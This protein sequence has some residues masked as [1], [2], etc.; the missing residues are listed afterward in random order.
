MNVKVAVPEIPMLAKKQIAEK[1]LKI[2]RRIVN[3]FHQILI[4]CPHQRIAE[5]PGMVCEKFIIDVE[6]YGAEIL[7]RKDRCSARVPFA[8]CVDLPYSGDKACQVGIISSWEI[9]FSVHDW[10]YAAV[11]GAV[12]ELVYELANT[13]RISYGHP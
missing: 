5:I 3:A 12:G 8:E 2:D 11:D 10:F 1:S 7:Y 4:V 13:L 9:S 6:A